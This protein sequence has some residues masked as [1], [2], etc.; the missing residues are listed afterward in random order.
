MVLWK[1]DAVI[2]IARGILPVARRKVEEK[3]AGF[4]PVHNYAADVGWVKSDLGQG[5]TFHFTLEP[6]GATARD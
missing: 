3:L 1:L 2:R 6:M 5:S 4:A